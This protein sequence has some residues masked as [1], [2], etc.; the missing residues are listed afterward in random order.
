VYSS[1]CVHS[2]YLSTHTHAAVD[3]CVHTQLCVYLGIH[4][5]SKS[6]STCKSIHKDPPVLQWRQISTVCGWTKFRP[7]V[8]FEFCRHSKNEVLPHCGWRVPK[9]REPGVLPYIH[10][11]PGPCR[12]RRVYGAIRID[13]FEWSMAMGAYLLAF[14]ADSLGAQ[15][16]NNK[17]GTYVY[18]AVT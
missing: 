6:M 5:G 17:F 4:T 15:R 13:Q 16:T 9:Y 14:S 10:T 12:I 2:V 7:H 3:L 1:V 18:T 11:A 8:I